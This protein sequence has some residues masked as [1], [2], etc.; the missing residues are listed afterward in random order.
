MFGLSLN[1]E[2]T[3]L[4]NSGLTPTESFIVRLLLIAVEGDTKPLVNYISNISDG[5]IEVILTQ[6]KGGKGGWMEPEQLQ[7]L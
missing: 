3:I 7:L 2:A 5:K 6:K 4:I 1:E